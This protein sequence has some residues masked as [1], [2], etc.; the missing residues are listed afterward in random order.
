VLLDVDVLNGLLE[1][2]FL[3]S[4]SIQDINLRPVLEAALS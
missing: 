3:G 4:H 1:Q 2:F